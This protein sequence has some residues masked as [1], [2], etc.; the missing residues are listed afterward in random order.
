M[1]HIKKI[2]F[3]EDLVLTMTSFIRISQKVPPE[4]VVFFQHLPKYLKKNKGLM[5]DLYELLN[6]YIVYGSDMFDNNLEYV[7]SLCDMIKKSITEFSAYEK[8]SYLGYN[9]LSLLLQV[10]DYLLIFF[11]SKRIFF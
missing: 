4:G 9:L 1:N 10:L 3:D 6:A 7:A 11:K 8:S 5:L 2:E